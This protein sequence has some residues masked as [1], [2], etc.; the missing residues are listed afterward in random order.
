MDDIIP[1]QRPQS[2][3]E[4]SSQEGSNYK[5]LFWTLKP[6]QNDATLAA[7][8]ARPARTSHVVLS[9]LSAK[10]RWQDLT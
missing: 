1:P 2:V 10:P 9:A 6:D 3:T 8:P 5:P 7:A 4:R